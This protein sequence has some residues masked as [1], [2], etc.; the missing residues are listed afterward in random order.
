MPATSG[1]LVIK[2]RFSSRIKRVRCPALCYESTHDRDYER[3]D[4]AKPRTSRSAPAFSAAR[5]EGERW[6]A[7]VSAGS[8]AAMGQEVI[9]GIPA[10]SQAWPR[11]ICQSRI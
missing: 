8:Q 3:T 4:C 9:S 11:S 2:N 5:L 7:A 10:R 1:T 6:R